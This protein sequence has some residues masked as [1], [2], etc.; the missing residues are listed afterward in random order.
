MNNRVNID[1]KF[2]IWCAR[3]TLHLWD[4]PEEVKSWLA[5][6][7]PEQAT[8]AADMAWDARMAE[9]ERSANARV[10]ADLV[11]DLDANPRGSIAAVAAIETSWTAAESVVA[12]VVSAAGEAGAAWMAAS[13]ATY[14]AQAFDTTIGQLRLDYVATWTDAELSRAEGEWIEAATAEIFE[15]TSMRLSCI[16]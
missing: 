12:T 1:V 16:P 14:A 15:R 13:A 6:P 8:K 5:D 10:A 7:K 9:V 11:F 3:Q 4:P 2:G